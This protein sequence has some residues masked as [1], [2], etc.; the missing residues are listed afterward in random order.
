MEPNTPKI[1]ECPMCENAL[2]PSSTSLCSDC[3][4][5]FEN[6]YSLYLRQDEEKEPPTL[7]PLRI[8]R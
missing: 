7:T 5:E 2:V 1:Y 6:E 4:K 3:K 8:W